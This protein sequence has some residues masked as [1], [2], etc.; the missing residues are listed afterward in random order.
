[1]KILIVFSFLLFLIRGIAVSQDLHPQNNIVAGMHSISSQVLYDHVRELT[2]EKYGGRLTGTPGY[3]SAAA[4]L[5]RFYQKYGLKPLGKNH[6]YLQ[7]FPIP[8]T[9]VLPDCKLIFH[10]P[11][12]N[13]T[14]YKDYRYVSEF[15]PGSTSDSG[16]IT[17]EVLYAG[18]AI[19]APELDYD[20][21]AGIDVKGKIV[22]IESEVPVSPNRGPEFFSKWEPYSYHQYK[23]GNVARHGAIGMLYNYGP[24]ANPNNSF[25]SGMIYSH[26]GD[27]VVGDLFKG[28]GKNHRETTDSIKSTLKPRSFPTGKTVTIENHSVHHPEGIGSNVLGILEGNDPVLKK[29]AIILGAHLDHLGYCYELMPGANDNASGVAVMMEVIRALK[30][31]APVL[32][33]SVIFAAF[34]AEEQWVVGSAR[35]IENPPFPL[36]KTIGLLNLDGVGAGDKITALGGLNFPEL[37]SA[38]DSA[39]QNYV[40]RNLKAVKFVNITRPRLDA[41]RF[42]KAGVPVLSFS[43]YGSPSVYHQPGDNLSTL[44]PEIMEDMARILYLG[45][46]DLANN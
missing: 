44:T 19:T 43:T 25:I 9:L 12:G 39:N 5:V 20:D 27:S 35:Y 11:M 30:E 16:R 33:R 29:E 13:E 14:L 38:V 41:A 21:F 8:Y 40:H 6:S 42:E 46:I 22:L 3:D 34:G 10:I 2:L 31:Y 28:T 4:W 17:A 15:I 32:K 45:I 18:Y 26:V 23:L 1:M 7:K 24:I 36:K 37:F